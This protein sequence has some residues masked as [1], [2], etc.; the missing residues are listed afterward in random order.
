M[1]T[2]DEIKIFEAI[3]KQLKIANRLKAVE[4]LKYRD[5]HPIWSFVNEVADDE[6]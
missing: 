3:E 4:L 6:S 5:E 1:L 2:D